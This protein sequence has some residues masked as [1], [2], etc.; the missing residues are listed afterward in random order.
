MGA[1]QDYTFWHN[2]WEVS[3]RRL[4]NTNQ[5]GIFL[6]DRNVG[7]ACLLS[8]TSHLQL[9]HFQ[10]LHGLGG[11]WEVHTGDFTDQGQAQI[12]LYDPSSGD[13]RMLVLKPDLSVVTQLDYTGWE[14]GQV[15][16]RGPL[17]PA[18]P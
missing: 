6:Y 18:C 2:S 8:F 15:L 1:T 7:E 5:D 16:L 11:T 14:T 12:L 9:A 10:F 3:V 17:W 4:V 13:A